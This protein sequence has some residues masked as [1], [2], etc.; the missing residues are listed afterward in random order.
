MEPPLKSLHFLKKDVMSIKMD[1][2]RRLFFLG[3][4]MALLGLTELEVEGYALSMLFYPGVAVA[5]IV[6]IWLWLMQ[7]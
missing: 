4:L 3:L 7:G 5:V 1:N 6:I 2:K